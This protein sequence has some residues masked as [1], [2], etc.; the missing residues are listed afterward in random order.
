MDLLDSDLDTD[1]RR[2]ED[3]SSKRLQDVL[4][5]EKLLH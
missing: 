2:L 5:E 4:E 3:M 1:S